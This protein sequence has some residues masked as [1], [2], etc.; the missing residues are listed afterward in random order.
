[1][2]CKVC[3]ANNPADAERCVKCGAAISACCPAC[4]TEVRAEARFCSNCGHS[5]VSKR[6]DTATAKQAN[7][8]AHASERRQVTILFAD[9]SGFTSFSAQLDPEDL[10]DTMNNLWVNLD[11]VIANHGGTPEKHSGD[12]IMAV[13]GGWKSREDDPAE[14][15]RAALSMQAWLE[16]RKSESGWPTLRMRIGIH[17]GVVVVGP[18]DHSGEFLATGDAVNLAS[19][20]EQSA[21]VGGV[22]V[23]RE[24]YGHVYGMFDAQAQPPLTVK[25][26][27]EP[28][29]T[30]LILRAKPRGLALQV[31]GIEGVETAMIGRREE[32]KQ[33]QAVF[34][35]VIRDR[36]TQLLTV[37]AEGGIGKSRLFREF[38]KWTDLLPQY[39]RLFC[40]RAT[41]E[42]AN[43]PFAL[44][45]DLFNTRF[46]IQESDSAPVARDKFERGLAALI[47]GDAR[48][49]E[50]LAEDVMVDIHLVGQL[51][52]LDFSASSHLR[53]IL[54]DLEQIRQRAFHGFVRLFTAISQCPAT[55][56]R[57]SIS[58]IMIVLDDLHW[59]DEGSLDLVEH[60]AR[61]C[62]WVPLM[63]LCSARPA[64]FEQRPDWCDGLSNVARLNLDPLSL[65][66]SDAMV[67]SILSKASDI[68]PA[69]RELVTE[70]A[71]GNP[72]YIE[73]MI[74]MLMDQ[75]VIVAQADAWQIELGRLLD[76]R[77]PST[78]TGVLQA[79]LDGLSSA[80]RAVIQR[81]SVVGRV[82]WDTSVEHMSAGAADA[83]S[84]PLF[85]STLTQK[86]IAVA[87][88]GLRRKGLVF[89]RDRSAFAGTVEYL[90][91]HELLRNVAYESL[92]KKT[93]RRHHGRLAE[94][95]KDH[96]GGRI[97]EFAGQVAAHFEL[98]VRLAEAAEWHGRA[99]QQARLGYAPAIASE[100]FKKA[101]Q[102][103][104]PDA[105]R[106]KALQRQQLEWQE[107]LVE[108]LG[109]QAHFSEAMEFCNTMRQLAKS[110]GDPAAE[111]RAWNHT[112]YLHERRGDN[113][114]S[115]HCAEQ[116]EALARSLSEAGRA[117]KIRALHI[118]GWAFYRLGEAPQ[119]LAL[120]QQTLMLC[121]EDENRRGM[122]TSFKLLGVAQLQL[123]NYAAANSFFE[124]GQALYREMGD[125]RNTAAMWSNR[126]ETARARGDFKTAADLYDKALSMVRQIA[127][128][129]SE[130]IYLC[131]L[132]GARLGLAQFAEAEMDLRH[133]IAQTLTPNSCTL[134]E[135]YTFLSEACL[136]QGKIAE[137]VASGQKALALARESESALYLG[138]AWRV[139]G[140]VGA[141]IAKSPKT[142]G[143]DVMSTEI[144]VP[145]PAHCFGESVKVFQSIDAQGEQA[146][147]L[148]EWGAY[149]VSRGEQ[150]QGVARLQEARAI[151]VKLDATFEVAITDRILEMTR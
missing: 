75:Q 108:T 78:L 68:P 143:G 33:L 76:A 105:A 55:E 89:R 90:F 14:A 57:P 65:S 38:Q 95:L 82:F 62:R 16:A 43:Q 27:G 40:G 64:F 23:S 71:E 8:K 41:S 140:K 101:L 107:G 111:A 144:S 11:A 29:E 47:N 128:R 148:R 137:S 70:G 97:H 10:R 118:K 36:V 45:A 96:S 124:Q 81:A 32:L 106:D 50:A 79:R 104:P 130:L 5:L 138:G 125:A 24:T 53:D 151:F 3:E 52:G 61:N 147:A 103:L 139:L 19:R 72:F 44:I 114:S 12:A 98:A 129:D 132:S 34:E 100:H 117:E 9:F 30:Y 121:A 116:A 4:G 25:G 93:R 126:G 74:K 6:D 99:A 39:F 91:K 35:N 7:V 122:A 15:I 56:Q 84:G 31:R 87:L 20:L 133:V 63:I 58:A 59:A 54:E 77:V 17:T 21:P 13:F 109:A 49:V 119:V 135:V 2:I 83:G 69:L 113:R 48:G 146:R 18:A 22:L 134:S 28:I 145:D 67:K 115:I 60:L 51:V 92:L 149:E 26:I 120:G 94:W 112:A 46:E 102:L 86:D 123:G 136:G 110:L 37:V 80:E 88:D 150:A 142:S 131:N 66:E 127:N 141:R 42:A 1:M 85:E 73:E